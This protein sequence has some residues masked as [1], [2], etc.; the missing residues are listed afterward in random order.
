MALGSGEGDVARSLPLMEEPSVRVQLGPAAWVPRSA[1]PSKSFAW[2]AVKT[3]AGPVGVCLQVY[4]LL[5][6][7]A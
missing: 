1:R 2:G 7:G 6:R 3:Q 5:R 4:G